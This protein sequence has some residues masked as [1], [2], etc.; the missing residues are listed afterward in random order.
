VTDFLISP[1]SARQ[2]QNTTLQTLGEIGSASQPAPFNIDQERSL[3]FPR[4]WLNVSSRALPA[5]VRA[6]VTFYVTSPERG[7][8]IESV[9]ED[10][11][12]CDEGERIPP[13]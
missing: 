4:A 12:G 6:V 8:A 7:A 3:L 11:S 1:P 9:E 13:G 2:D 5:S 10:R